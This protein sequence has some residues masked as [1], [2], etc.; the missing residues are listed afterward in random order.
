MESISFL[1][2]WL[3]L[4]VLTRENL[5]LVNGNIVRDIGEMPFIARLSLKTGF[6]SSSICG[7]SLIAPQYLLSAKH[8]FRKQRTIPFF[9]DQCIYDRDCVAHFRDL[10]VSGFNS[11]DRGQFYIPIVDIFERSGHSD[12]VVVK[13]KHPVEE[14]ED[15][16]LGSPLFP[17]KLASEETK[18]GDSVVTAG[19]GLTGYNEGPSNELRS[20][21]LNVTR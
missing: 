6:G 11:H 13:L 5:A 20:L 8:C 7:A 3:C 16:K 17:I 4:L 19:W 21:E 2:F 10:R 15:Y 1:L 12:L 14:H 18:G 9:Y